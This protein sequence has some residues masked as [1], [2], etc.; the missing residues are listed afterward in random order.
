MS[1]ART[2]LARE[3]RKATKQTQ[4]RVSSVCVETFLTGDFSKSMFPQK[5]KKYFN[6]FHYQRLPRT[7]NIH[8]LQNYAN[9]VSYPLFLPSGR[10]ESDWLAK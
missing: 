1:A 6:R 5:K 4:K 2:S 7:D 10:R 9:I 8:P 3:L